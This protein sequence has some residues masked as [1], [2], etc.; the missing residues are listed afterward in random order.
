[1]KE[2]RKWPRRKTHQPPKP[3][4]L[5]EMTSTLKAE[6]EQHLQAA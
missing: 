3:P 1:M 4:I 6:V 2:K 5:L